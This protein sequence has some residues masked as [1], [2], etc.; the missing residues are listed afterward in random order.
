MKR[1][2]TLASFVLAAAMLFTA[3][4][5]S[6]QLTNS[7]VSQENNSHPPKVK[8]IMVL[9][10]FNNASNMSL[11][12]NM[13]KELIRDLKAYRVDAVGALQTY[14]PKAFE[15]LTE[16]QALAKLQESGS[17]AVLTVRLLDKNKEKQ[18]VP[19]GYTPYPYGGF[20]G[21]YSY[22]SPMV[23]QPGYYATSTQ[24]SFE[25]NLYQLSNEQLLYSAQSASFNPSSPQGLADDYA[26][27]IVKDLRK[28]RAIGK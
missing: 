28:K 9:A 5:S 1:T 7:W 11:R 25:S 23:Y 12:S 27:M 21:Y 20:W 19:G 13:E 2:I 10:M 3:C 24:Y 16:S 18:Y 26:R 22:Y 17:D 8:K 4:S 15:G 6:T 14:G